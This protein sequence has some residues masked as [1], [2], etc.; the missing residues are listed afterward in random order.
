MIRIVIKNTGN[1]PYRP[2][3]WGDDITIERT[4]A[5]EGASGWKVK[6]SMPGVKNPVATN[7]AAVIDMMDHFDIQADN[8]MTILTQDM[9]RAF[10][11]TSDA[12]K[13]Y[14]VSEWS[15]VGMIP[16]QL[17]VLSHKLFLKGT[18]LKKLMDEYEELDRK[19][20]AIKANIDRQAA[21]I[22]DL[23]KDAE[24]WRKLHQ[25]M[26]TLQKQEEEI[27]ELQKDL[28]WAHVRD[29][30]AEVNDQQTKLAKLKESLEA[31][32]AFVDDYDVSKISTDRGA[33]CDIPDSLFALFI[34]LTD[35]GQAC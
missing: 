14:E 28:V 3:I 24:K 23:R 33:R 12:H 7:R 13:K 17:T 25:D 30:L 11:S 4:L 19:A 9:S 26:E 22:D 18:R 16:A 1:N 32:Q 31:A 2:E 21:G 34:A 5:K 29:K 35:C 20:Y 15:A 10:L 6:S 27:E 8:P